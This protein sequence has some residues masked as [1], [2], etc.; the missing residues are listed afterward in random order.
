M[1]G[2]EC[3][4]S[5]TTVPGKW[6]NNEGDTK[7]GDTIVI[8]DCPGFD[9]RGDIVQEIANG[10]YIDKILKTTKEIKLVLTVSDESLGGSKCQMF[11]D[12][13]K[14]FMGMNPNYF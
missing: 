7:E 1:I 14:T 11:I 3:A 9:H 12:I 4:K 5:T 8:W 2:N 13:L 6:V 10:F